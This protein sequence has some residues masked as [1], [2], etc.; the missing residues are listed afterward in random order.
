M[1]VEDLVDGQ[2]QESEGKGSKQQKTLQSRLMV[3][4]TGHIVSLTHLTFS[5]NALMLATGCAKGWLNIWSLQV[6]TVC[7]LSLLTC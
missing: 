7:S 6:C 4:F 5:P 2:F 1:T 3:S